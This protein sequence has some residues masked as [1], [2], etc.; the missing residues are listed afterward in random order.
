M[1]RSANEYGCGSPF[2]TEGYLRKR[3]PVFKL[4]AF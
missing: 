3:Q 1:M 2:C 4:S